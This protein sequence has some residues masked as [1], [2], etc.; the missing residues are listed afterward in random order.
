MTRAR[1]KHVTSSLRNIIVVN[2]THCGCQMGLIPRDG[3]VV[4]GGGAYYPSPMQQKLWTWWEVFWGEWV[5][6]VTKREPYAVVVNGD[7]LEGNH[8]GA[9]SQITHNLKDQGEIAYQCFKPIAKKAEGGFYMLRGTE[10]HGGQSG[11]DEEELAKRLG[12]ISDRDGRHAR[13]ELWKRLGPY[14]CHFTHHVGTGPTALLNEV[15]LAFMD[16]GLMGLKPPNVVVR[17]HQHY[18]MEERVSSK[19]G[20][21]IGVVVPGWQLKT[22]HSYRLARARN[23]Q[24]EVGGLLIRVGDEELYTRAKVWRL[25][26]PEAE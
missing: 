6:R 13:W 2:D 24:P 22:P 14:L 19:N 9:V 18:F 17:G 11:A 5:P 10:A 25:D 20:Y 4:D 16:A 15:R 21:C 3:V 26:R 12:A 1:Q 8:H 7:P 23:S